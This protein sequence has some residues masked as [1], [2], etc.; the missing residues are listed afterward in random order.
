MKTQKNYI[1]FDEI[2]TEYV[3]HYGKNGETKLI[4]DF[5]KYLADLSKTSEIT[6]ITRQEVSKVASW[7]TKNDLYQFTDSIS[8]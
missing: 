7:F 5:K 6:V 4:K 8:N 3:N 2:F 1:F